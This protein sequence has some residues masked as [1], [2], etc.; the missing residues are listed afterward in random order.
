MKSREQD[1][2]NDST[3]GHA[4]MEEGKPMGP[5]LQT[6]NYMQSENA[7]SGRNGLQQGRAPQLIV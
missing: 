6:N 5:Q 3:N 7:E 1:L 4:D 2:N